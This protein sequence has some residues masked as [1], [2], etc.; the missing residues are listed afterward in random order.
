[1]TVDEIL[2]MV[3]AFGESSFSCGKHSGPPE[4]YIQLSEVYRKL[5]RSLDTEISRMVNEREELRISLLRR[6]FEAWT[7][8]GVRV[9]YCRH[10]E[11]YT[12][13]GEQIPH[14]PDCVVR[15]YGTDQ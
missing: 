1:M 4:E 5:Y 8:D 10:C 6:A 2:N 13:M 7:R 9:L 12:P 3:S 15:K 11:A 14:R